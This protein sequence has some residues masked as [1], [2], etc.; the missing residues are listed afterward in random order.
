MTRSKYFAALA[1]GLSVVAL[2][3]CSASGGADPLAAPSASGDTIVVGSQAYYSNEII[4]EIYAEALESDGF[5]VKRQFNIGQREAYLPELES[6]GVDLFPEYTGPLLQYW[7]PTTTLTQA[8]EVYEALR[9]AAPA[10]LQVLDQS[11]ATDQDAYAVTREFSEQYGVTSLADLASVPVPLVVGGNAEGVDRPNG[12]KG[13]LEHYGVTVGFTPIDDGGGPLTVSSLKSGAIQ[14]G[15]VYTASPTIQ[16]G[17]LV[18]LD[19]PENLFTA[20]H[21]VPVASDSLPAG[22]ADTV[23]RISAA[24]TPEDLIAMN[25]QSVD[26]QQSSDAI[27][28]GWLAAHPL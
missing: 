25:V 15:I 16:S 23:N 3:G 1:L 5:A 24:L 28:A 19:D 8:D 26:G 27:A 21:V 6:G 4:A 9:A 17:D 12:P 14:L 22:A 7:V 2:A 11:A 18:I 10:G 13:L 20:S